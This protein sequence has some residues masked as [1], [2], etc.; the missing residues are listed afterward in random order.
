MSKLNRKDLGLIFEPHSIALAGISL[1]N[2]NHWTRVFLESLLEFAFEGPIYLVNPRGGELKGFEV[3]R[4]LR[5]IPDAVDYVISTVG[6]KASPRLV[7]ECA[8]K[9]VRAIHFCTAGFSETGEEEGVRLEAQLA[10]VSEEKGIR[11]IGPNC[12]GIYCPRSRLSFGVGFPKE[13]GPVALVSQSGGN[14]ASIVNQ[15]GWRGVRFSKVVSYGNACDLNES[16][17]I[18]YFAADPD[19]TVIA[20][21]LEGVKDGS[22]F[23][24]VLERAAEEK[25]VVLLKGGLSE[26]GA[27]AVA[28]HTGALAGNEVTWNALCKQLGIIRVYAL[29]ELVDEL[30]TLLFMPVP[31]GRN[32]ALIGAGGGNSVLIADEF[33]KRGL[34]VP[35]LPEELRKLIREFSP[36]AGNIFRN[37]I[38]YSQTFMEAGKLG[39]VV[40]IISRWKGIDFLIGFLDLS[41]FAGGAAAAQWVDGVD[42]MLEA[43]RK[44]SKP[45]A[46][47]MQLGTV[48]EDAKAVLALSQ[49]FIQAQLP[50]YLSFSGAANSINLMLT[51][52]ENRGGGLE[53]RTR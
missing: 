7:E 19:T 48:P 27:R 51:H 18:E 33:E 4:S 1:T 36:A 9:G 11:I 50:T 43:S 44:S 53:A 10:E 40:N 42:G 52:N 5:D 14:A 49:R 3:Y 16:D 32:V 25:V 15:A 6:A 31:Q 39:E 47:V 37:P 38:D 34:K 28:G 17:F 26:G 12:M 22:K 46:M 45:M 13:S 24:R 30:E 2:P 23:H 35:P 8:I 29:E 41:G 21:Y 20:L